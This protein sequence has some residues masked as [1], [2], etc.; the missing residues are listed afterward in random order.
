MSTR[1]WLVTV[2]LTFALAPAAA[3]ADD[4]ADVADVP[5]RDL[6]AG[7]DAQKRYLLIG[8][9]KEATKIG[10]LDRA[11]GEGDVVATGALAALAPFRITA[12]SS[13]DGTLPSR[14]IHTHSAASTFSPPGPRCCFEL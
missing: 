4:A 5:A 6:R 9:A 2:A 11:I 3:R 13:R 8:P 7:G 14:K 12:L 10:C 1:R